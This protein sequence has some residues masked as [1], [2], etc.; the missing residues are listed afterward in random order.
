MPR[1]RVLASLQ[2]PARRA[3]AR[4]PRDR[5]P[6]P[7]AGLVGGRSAGDDLQGSEAR[8]H[9]C[10]RT[11]REL[12]AGLP[13]AR[14]G[15]GDRGT[16]RD[17]P[18]G[19]PAG[20]HAGRPGRHHRRRRQPAEP[21]SRRLAADRRD[22]QALASQIGPVLGDEDPTDDQP[23]RPA[24]SP[25]RSGPDQRRRR[26][27]HRM[28]PALRWKWMLWGGVVAGGRR[29]RPVRSSSPVSPQAVSP[30]TSQSTLSASLRSYDDHWSV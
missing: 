2:A 13:A 4:R 16:R 24:L 9:L 28:P 15:R 5:R 25:G 8:Q 19:G 29:G 20:G 27:G 14:G 30:R 12:P 3:E 6:G 1:E 11:D 18:R 21:A 17:R 7:L 26:R 22:D 23:G 10:P